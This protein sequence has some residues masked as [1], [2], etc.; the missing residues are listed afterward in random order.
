MEV[1]F[2]FSIFKMYL[3]II[4][5]SF[6]FSL[7]GG[8]SHAN[9]AEAAGAGETPRYTPSFWQEASERNRLQQENVRGVLGRRIWRRGSLI[10]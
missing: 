4:I 7:S 10:F 9:Y 6:L 1:L 2:S 5:N 3:I 8:H